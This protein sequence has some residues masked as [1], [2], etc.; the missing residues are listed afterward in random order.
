M[1]INGKEVFYTEKQTQ[2]IQKDINKVD[3]LNS[4][5]KTEVDVKKETS[6]SM[7]GFPDFELNTFFDDSKFG[8]DFVTKNRKERYAIYREM[9]TNE[10]IHRGVEL[11][12]DDS[13]QPNDEGNVIKVYSEDGEIKEELEDLFARRL[14]MNNELWSIFYETCKLGDNFFE[15]IPNDYKKPKEIV[16]IRYLTP[17]RTER[18]EKNDKLSHFLYKTEK[19]DKRGNKI[20]EQNFKLWPWQIAHFKIE[21][22]DN[23]PYGGSLLASG[24]RT[25]KRLALLEDVMLV[26]RISRAPERRVFYIDVGNLTPVEAKRFLNK[27]KNSYRSQSIIDENG[28]LN[29]QSNVLSITSDIFIPV[30]EG[31]QG[32]RIDTLQPGQAMGAQGSE[33]PLLEYFKN[34]ILRTMNIP[35]AYLGEQADRS[36]SLSNLDQKFGRFIERVQAQIIK[37]LNKIAALE[38]YFKGYKKEDLNNFQIELTPPSNVKEITEIDI[39]NQKMT[40]IGTIMQLELFPQQWILKKILKLSNKEISQIMFQKTM[41][42]QAGATEGG[43]EMPGMGGGEMPGVSGG[44]EAA[45]G[46][47]EAAPEELAASTVINVLGKDFLIENKKDMYKLFK[48]IQEENEPNKMIPLLE[49]LSNY[50]LSDQT[51]NVKKSQNNIKFLLAEN[52]FDGIDFEGDEI[53]LYKKNGNLL[54]EESEYYTVKVH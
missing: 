41:E 46:G 30:R 7:G 16:K 3:G 13:T 40:L 8:E 32:T 23:D 51:T 52:E 42:Q 34:K 18:V 9:M 19:K 11:I 44:E 31:T 6:D 20:E 2:S 26:Y 39:I 50:I 22:K 1:L 38:L 37:G 15:V 45:A 35:P 10:F 54:S 48:K 49:D 47:E 4:D 53:S 12:A 33:D 28:N 14:D 24:A 43:G 36:R 21:D 17:D 5:L 29:K 27:M 25:Y